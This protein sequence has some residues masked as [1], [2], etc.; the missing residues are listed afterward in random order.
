MADT[1][2]IARLKNFYTNKQ[3]S[4]SEA[5]Y[6]AG[7]IDGEGCFV[8]HKTP[9]KG[10]RLKAH[11]IRHVLLVTLSVTNTD[12]SAL[13]RIREVAGN[14][15]IVIEHSTG[16]RKP[17]GTW[18][19]NQ[20]QVEVLV[21]QIIPHMLIKREQAE[22]ALKFIELKNTNKDL[23]LEVSQQLEALWEKVRS[24]NHRG[25]SEKHEQE[26]EQIGLWSPD[27]GC[28]WPG[29]EREHYGKG[30]CR[31]HHKW[32]FESKTFDER[33]ARLCE[34]CH[35][36][37]AGDARIDT[38][39]CS[40]SCKMKYHRAQGCYTAEATAASRG[41]CELE[42]CENPV[43]AQGL[44]RT[45]YMRAWRHGDVTHEPP[46]PEKCAVDGCEELG[47]WKGMCKRHYANQYYQQ[48]SDTINARVRAWRAKRKNTPA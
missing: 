14:G 6:L 39:F 17:R 43:H 13:A 21:P 47:I 41:V 4:V 25:K 31:R 19:I 20:K 30:Y 32:I 37:L 22:W 36:P 29:C 45:H 11:G 28:S 46:K 34:Y 26:A 24:F 42:G 8:T 7:I 40:T 38:K 27:K 12:Y 9:S 1:R 10:K 16:N 33:V 15:R 2:I 3:L 5:A 18:Y 35:K 23:T 48:N 44:C